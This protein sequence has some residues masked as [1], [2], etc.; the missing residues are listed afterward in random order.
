MF[1]AVV[2]QILVVKLAED[3]TR[4]L[5]QAGLAHLRGIGPARRTVCGDPARI[6]SPPARDADGRQKCQQT[7][8]CRDASADMEDLRGI[9]IEDEPPPAQSPGVINGSA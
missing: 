5:R 6:A 9:D 1:G 4:R 3:Y 8:A 7:A 2:T